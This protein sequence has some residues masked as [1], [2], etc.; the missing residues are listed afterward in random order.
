MKI[1]IILGIDIVLYSILHTPSTFHEDMTIKE[2]NKFHFECPVTTFRFV[3]FIAFY[4]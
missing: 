3:Y 4:V 2:E 1:Q